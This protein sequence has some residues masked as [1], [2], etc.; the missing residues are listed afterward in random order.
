MELPSELFVSKVKYPWNWLNGV[1]VYFPTQCEG[2]LWEYRIGDKIL[3]GIMDIMKSGEKQNSDSDMTYDSD[4]DGDSCNAAY[5]YKK[6]GKWILTWN[7]EMTL[8][9][10]PLGG[11]IPVGDWSQCVVT[12]DRPSKIK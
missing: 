4:T 11:K 8:S 2:D 7:F 12:I 10:G 6:R 3:D 5:I 1:Y 9:E